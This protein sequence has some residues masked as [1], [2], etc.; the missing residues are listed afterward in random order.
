MWIK[1][2]D[3]IFKNEEKI[4]EFLEKHLTVIVFLIAIIFNVATRYSMRNFT[5]LD[6]MNPL[7]RWYN[8]IKAAGGFA[9]LAQEPTDC[10]YNIPY[11]TL[12]AIFT[13]LPGGHIFW[14]KTSSGICDF[15]QAFAVAKIVYDLAKTNKLNKAAIAFVVAISS[16]LVLL[17][18]AE[19]GQCDSVYA[20]FIMLALLFLHEEK[21]KTSFL[22]VGIG[23]GFKLQA[24]FILPVFLFYYFYKKKF[25]IVYFAIIPVVM[26]IMSIP[27]IIAGRG[28]F[29]VFTKYMHQVDWYPTMAKNYPTFWTLLTNLHTV[30]NYYV[31]KTMAVTTT[32]LIIGCVMYAVIYKKV[33]LNYE[34]LLRLAFITCFTCSVFLPGMHERYAYLAEILG[35]VMI[36]I[37]WKFIPFVI[38]MNATTLATYGDFLF[39]HQTL[40]D[41]TFLAWVNVTVY[42]GMV[43]MS[44]YQMFIKPAS[45]EANKIN[46]EN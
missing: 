27:A 20:A 18:S 22:M 19:W 10:S 7:T 13:Y 6:L 8:E 33:E 40:E 26:E 24:I 15:I 5:N 25:S 41:Y 42:V 46:L 12:I 1:G 29:D 9:G 17:N 38:G 34:N 3:M 31:L 43:L 39:N 44:C 28:V 4:L 32:I 37:D 30:E 23:L 2:I 36:F 11:L 21:Y 14:Y 35:M 45:V 16:P